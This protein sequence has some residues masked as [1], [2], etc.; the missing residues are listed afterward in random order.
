[1]IHPGRHLSAPFE[2]IDVLREVDTNL[3]RTIMCHIERTIDQKTAL[4]ELAETECILEYDLFGIEHSYFPWTLPVDMP[5]D[6]GRLRWL[7]WLI[8]EGHGSQIVISHDIAMKYLLVR[9]GGAGYAHILD[10]VVPL[11]ERMGFKEEDIQTILVD[12]PARLFA[13]Q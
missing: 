1:M 13:F 3:G 10:N 9:Y 6:A 8:A 7:E 5:N 11:M 2:I 12:T 4:K